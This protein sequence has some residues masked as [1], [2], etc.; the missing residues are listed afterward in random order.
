MV[1]P[2]Q[3][4]AVIVTVDEWSL[5]GHG[6]FVGVPHHEESRHDEIMPVRTIALSPVPA[7]QQYPRADL[8]A[9]LDS[10]GREYV[11]AIWG[12]V[13]LRTP[14]STLVGGG[15]LLWHTHAPRV[16]EQFPQFVDVDGVETD[17]DPPVP[18]VGRAGQEE[19]V[20]L[21]GHERGTLIPGEPEPH[22]PLITGERGVDDL[23]NAELHLVAHERLV[24]SRERGGDRP[25]VVDRYSDWR[26]KTT[27][28]FHTSETS[29]R[30]RID[31]GIG[32]WPVKN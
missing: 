16:D 2:G 13:T 8:C 7:R 32:H 17:A 12:R 1:A 18:H 21:G 26:R 9:P 11:R 31:R 10:R 6:Q 4:T 28:M 22:H 29:R 24:G 19:L 15:D 23:A 27:S 14:R 5:S 3:S 30:A 20:G 25:G